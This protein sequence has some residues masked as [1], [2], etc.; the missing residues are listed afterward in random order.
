MKFI[1]LS[2]LPIPYPDETSSSFILRTSSLNGY[3]SPK[4]LLNSAGYKTYHTTLESICSDE[5]KFKE[6]LKYLGYDSL[7]QNLSF[8]KAQP[9]NQY[10][11][12]NQENLVSNKLINHTM[13]KFCSKCLSE[14]L[15]W[16]QSWLLAPYTTCTIHHTKLCIGCPNCNQN[17]PINRLKLYECPSCKTDFSEY[18]TENQCSVYDRWLLDSLDEDV[19]SFNN[20]FAELWTAFK[21][22]FENLKKTPDLHTIL[23]YCYFYFN[24]QKKF[25][26][27]LNELVIQ[28]LEYLHPKI[29]LLP[30]LKRSQKLTFSI[31][32]MVRDIQFS[33][34]TSPNLINFE[35]NKTEASII[36]NLCFLS[37]NRR[38]RDGKLF[39]EELNKNGKLVFTTR[40]LEDWL[41]F[42]KKVIEQQRTEKP[43]YNEQ[44]EAHLYYDRQ[45]IAEYLHVNLA[46][47]DK[48][49]RM[50]S[51][52]LTS[53]RLNGRKKQCISIENIHLFDNNYI[54]LSALAKKLK[55]SPINLGAKLQ[56]QNIFPADESERFS[57]YFF[58]TDVDKITTEKIESITTYQN[59][60]GRPPKNIKRAQN[61]FLSLNEC[62][63]IL[64]ISKLQTAQLIIKQYLKVYDL[65]QRPYKIPRK[66][67]DK[68]INE[69][70]DPSY[71]HLNIAE[72]ALDCNL[73][74]FL[75]NWVQ[76]GFIEI[77]S[78][79]YWHYVPIRQLEN[80]I[81]IH[82]EY[83]TASEANEYLGMHRTHITNLVKQG[84]IEQHVF[85]NK[86]FHV[87][88]F[89]KK[90][91]IRLK[92]LKSTIS[93]AI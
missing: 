32:S 85:G 75:K 21:E 17:L 33:T 36:L 63:E 42:K 57:A 90:D 27:I 53:K 3:T 80:A 50:P 77:K 16:R 19:N 79:L 54:F 23:T 31:F 15:Y 45:Q 46:V 74:Q 28:N 11:Y 89:K 48:Y 2:H 52:G 13:N 87:R 56:S 76:T 6:A 59:K 43:L 81:K 8:P 38:I 14:A 37:L 22:Y 24:D 66:F 73:Q 7:N 20:E 44:D 67:L 18:K 51:S 88:M 40:I 68:F 12:W 25:K 5:M 61:D 29:Q 26:D 83:F 4:A 58:R 91:V 64:G 55:V 10:V 82:S 86:S 49:M 60:T 62:G 69:M 84:L 1:K 92:S 71:V 93:I 30:F 35:V 39:H 34:N 65:E 72:K 47:V 70:N 41:I 9:T 78:L